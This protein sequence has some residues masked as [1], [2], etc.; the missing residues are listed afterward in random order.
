MTV[1]R[2]AEEADIVLPVATGQF[3]PLWSLDHD[4]ILKK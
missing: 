3:S 1:G 4:L 2:V